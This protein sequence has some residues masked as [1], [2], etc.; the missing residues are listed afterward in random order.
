MA[1]STLPPSYLGSIGYND[2]PE[3]LGE[4]GGFWLFANYAELWHAFT[5]SES[6]NDAF[7]ELGEPT[8]SRIL[9]GT[10]SDGAIIFHVLVLSLHPIYQE[11]AQAILDK[12]VA[13][14]KVVPKK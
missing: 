9:T 1:D 14:L 13:W 7:T 11:Q 8:Y 3:A 5:I 10:D 2:S 12:A 6:L 4:P